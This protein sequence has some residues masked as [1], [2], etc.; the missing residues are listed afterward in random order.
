MQAHTHA[1]PHLHNEPVCNYWLQ[2]ILVNAVRHVI[3]EISP[4]HS[5]DTRT[6]IHKILMIVKAGT[7]DQ[8]CVWF[9]CMFRRHKCVCAVECGIAY[10]LVGPG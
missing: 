2:R 4:T 9:F 7:L 5:N 3:C 6:Y 1:S 10:A 8:T